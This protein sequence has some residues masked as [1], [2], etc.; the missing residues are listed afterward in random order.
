MSAQQYLV[1]IEAV[2]AYP[3]LLNE[4]DES[5]LFFTN[6]AEVFLFFDRIL[7]H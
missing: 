6:T 1:G 7:V 2:D 5:I 3:F 4:L